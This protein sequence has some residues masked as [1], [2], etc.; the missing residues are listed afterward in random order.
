MTNLEIEIAGDIYP[1][2]RPEIRGDVGLSLRDSFVHVLQQHGV[3][4]AEIRINESDSS[5]VQITTYSTKREDK[6]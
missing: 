6:D 1:D 5:S 2:R 3:Q 4:N